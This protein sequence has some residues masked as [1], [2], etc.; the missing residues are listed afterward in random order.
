MAD[1]PSASPSSVP[2]SRWQCLQSRW[3]RLKS[4]LKTQGRSL[5]QT[6]P[7][8]RQIPGLG[9]VALDRHRPQGVIP[10]TA[11]WVRR[12]SPPGVAYRELYA[13]VPL[14]RTPPQTLDDP[15]QWQFTLDYGDR[16]QPAFLLSLPQGRCWQTSAIITAQHHLL[17]DLSI[18]FKID[19]RQTP[20]KHPV[21]WQPIASPR[22]HPGPLAVVI[23]PGGNTYFH[24]LIDVLPRFHLLRQGCGQGEFP[25]WEAIQG[26]V[27]NGYHQPFQQQT[28][29]LLGIDRDR[30][31]DGTAHPHWQ[32]DR[33]LVPSLPRHGT[34][35]IAPWVFQFL[36]QTFLL[37]PTTPPSPRETVNPGSCPQRLYISRG[38]AR[39]RRVL[40]EADLITLLQRWDFEVVQLEHLSFQD[41][42]AR[43]AAAQW[44]VAPHGAG[45]TNL[46]F[47][48]PGTQVLE[49]YSP[50]Y[51]SVSYWNICSQVGLNYTYLF[52]RGD[53]PP[54]YTTP[55]HLTADLEVDLAQVQRVL[56]GWHQS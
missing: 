39:R 33:L 18:H 24:W 54:A 20:R 29:D 23:A 7:G 37:S 3:Q 10:S 11:A 41:Q 32:A 15:V 8:L 53:R 38:S 47:C 51:V 26:F 30:C 31:V 42:V 13:D 52:S 1:L 45:L 9:W 49:I 56:E 25:P 43:F 5:L 2:F 14:H 40:N 16:S 35:A 36:R 21:F 28:L 34:C 27:V 4:R 50:H 46:V 48:A 19:P 44:V 6:L 22:S 17:G 55:H 12:D